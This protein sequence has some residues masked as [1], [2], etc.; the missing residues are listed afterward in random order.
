[1]YANFHNKNGGSSMIRLA[2]YLPVYRV[3][4]ILVIEIETNFFGQATSNGA[5]RPGQHEEIIKQES[6]QFLSTF[7]LQL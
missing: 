4:D 6:F 7:D 3:H 2:T 5:L 1:M